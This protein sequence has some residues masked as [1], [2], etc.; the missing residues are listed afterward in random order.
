MFSSKKLRLSIKIKATLYFKSHIKLI[1]IFLLDSYVRPDMAEWYNQNGKNDMALEQQKACIGEVSLNY[2]HDLIVNG[3][4]VSQNHCSFDGQKRSVGKRL[5]YQ[6]IYHL[7]KLEKA[8]QSRIQLDVDYKAISIEN[9]FNFRALSH[10]NFWQFMS[11][12]CSLFTITLEIKN[13]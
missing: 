8:P 9:T 5:N 4:V 7:H 13:A 12:E 1:C 2:H 11:H 3:S 10:R 6:A